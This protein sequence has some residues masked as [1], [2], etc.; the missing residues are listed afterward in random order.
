MDIRY[1]TKLKGKKFY[2]VLTP[3]GKVIFLGT[4]GECRRFL[5][6]HREKVRRH[7]ARSRHLPN[8]VIRLLEGA[9]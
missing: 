1:H 6:I 5:N 8:E 4:H 2:E 9:R 3:C 7:F